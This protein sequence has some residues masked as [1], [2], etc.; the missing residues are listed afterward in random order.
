MKLY[1]ITEGLPNGPLDPPCTFIE[2]EDERG[3]SIGDSSGANW[4]PYGKQSPKLSKLG[5]FAS[6][7][8]VEALR[9]EVSRLNNKID[10]LLATG[11]FPDD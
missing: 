5:P 11:E 8:E 10:E 2:L 7:T 6:Y 4:E 9:A 3:A 1:V